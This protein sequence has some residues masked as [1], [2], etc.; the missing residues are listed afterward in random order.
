MIVD[1][2]FDTMI[3]IIIC[4]IAFFMNMSFF[5]QEINKNEKLLEHINTLVTSPILYGSIL[6]LIVLIYIIFRF[7]GNTKIVVKIKDLL[8]DIL[9]D[10]KSI[11]LMKDKVWIAI[12]TIIT[13]LLYFCYFYTTFY[14]FDFTKDL[15]IMAGLIAFSMSSLSMV[16]P[17]QGGLGPWQ[18]AV[19]A[20]LGLYGVDKLEATAFATGVFSVQSL[21]II[22]W[23]VVGILS[24]SIESKAKDKTNV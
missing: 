23:G 11:W 2:L 7:F 24:L 10:L 15:G 12:Y 20:A 9:N 13:W 3:V 14:A 5:I 4:M 8:R 1:R 16:I 17:T 19:I 21:W 6:G 18:V 22:G